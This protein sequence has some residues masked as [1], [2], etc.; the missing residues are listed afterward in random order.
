MPVTRIDGSGKAL[1]DPPE[2][3]EILLG[4]IS[5]QTRATQGSL[6]ETCDDDNEIMYRVLYP[7]FEEL[8]FR[9]AQ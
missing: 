4:H 5:G 8:A 3:P 9:P 2:I 6:K 7:L 1:V